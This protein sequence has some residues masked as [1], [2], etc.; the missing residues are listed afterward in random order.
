MVQDDKAAVYHR[1]KRLD[2][3]WWVCADEFVTESWPLIPLS[4]LGHGPTCTH[5][6]R[7]GLWVS[8]HP[9]GGSGSLLD[10]H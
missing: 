10:P 1:D 8:W 4:R 9:A 3:I 2:A 7:D 6:G 5:A